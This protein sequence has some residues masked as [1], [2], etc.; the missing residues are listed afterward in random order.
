MAMYNYVNYYMLS[1]DILDIFPADSYM[2]L[3]IAELLIIGVSVALFYYNICKQMLFYYFFSPN[4][5]PENLTT[6]EEQKLNLEQYINVRDKYKFEC[7]VLTNNL[8]IKNLQTG[9]IIEA[10]TLT[11]QVIPRCNLLNII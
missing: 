3:Y 4:L 6:M 10:L 5:T 2:V 11:S 1:Q 8:G 7:I 9:E